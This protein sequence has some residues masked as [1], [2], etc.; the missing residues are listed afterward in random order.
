MEIVSP[1]IMDETVL[2]ATS[3]KDPFVAVAGLA[4]ETV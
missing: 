3:V 2:I 1:P 4:V